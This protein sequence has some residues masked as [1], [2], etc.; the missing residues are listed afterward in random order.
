MVFL[1]V[2]LAIAF[3]IFPAHKVVQFIY[4]KKGSKK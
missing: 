2:V 3:F 1:I 4:G